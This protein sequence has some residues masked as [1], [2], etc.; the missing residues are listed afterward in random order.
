MNKDKGT[1]AERELFHKFWDAGYGVVR[2]AGSGSVPLPSCDLLVSS[3]GRLFVLE[4][5]HTQ[6]SIKYF[7]QKE[8]DDLR[9]IASRFCAEPFIA[10]KFHY[11]GWYFFSLDKLERRKQNYS[12]SLSCLEEGIPFACFPLE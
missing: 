4:C 8:I 9:T 2:V 3:K 12:I 5:K 7:S 6:K 10:I 1:R 11:K